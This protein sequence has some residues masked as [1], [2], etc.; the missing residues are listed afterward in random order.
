MEEWKKE[1]RKEDNQ[2]VISLEFQLNFQTGG[3]QMY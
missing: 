3:G 2:F 1:R